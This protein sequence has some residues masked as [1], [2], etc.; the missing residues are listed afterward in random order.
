MV[1]SKGFEIEMYTGTTQGDIVGLSDKITATLDGF[2]REPDSRN[3]EYVTA[4][5]YDYEKLLCG[6]L[7]PRLKLRKY[8]KQL[9]H[10]TLIPGS[11]LSLG[12]S[13][14]FFRS[15]PNNSYHEYIEKTYGTK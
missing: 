13:E 8:L 11:T 12:G 15:D 9:G 4:P 10:Y 2:M 3:V 14:K 1:L 5:Y 7:C 6:L